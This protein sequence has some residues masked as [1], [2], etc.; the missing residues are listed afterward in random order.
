VKIGITGV[1]GFIGSNL[2]DALL[3][4]GHSVIGLDNLSM[5][6]L[7]NIEQHARCPNFEF[8]KVDVRDL[9]GMAAAFRHVDCVIHLAAF[10]IPRY[11]KAIETL[12][13][14]STGGKNV[15]EVC[16]D[17]SR[18]AVIAS[19]SDIYGKNPNLPFREDSD[20]LIGPTIIPR[21]SYAVSKLFD[22]H[23]SLA[24]YSGYGLPVTI[25]RFFG[26]YGPRQHLTWWGGPQS[27]F[28]SAVLNDKPM[29]IHGD[30]KQT[31]SFTYIADLIDG[32]VRATEHQSDTPQVFN[33]GNTEEV[34]ILDLARL[35]HELCGTGG[36]IN[37]K[38]VPY[39]SIG[40]NYEDV[41]RRIPDITKARTL[42]GFNPRVSLR[43]GLVPTIEWQRC[44]M[45]EVS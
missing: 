14:N 24:Y 27:V 26:S 40:G 34:T 42:L 43:D 10:K 22:E 38:M 31:R 9:D 5:G 8:C 20:S 18:R 45:A 29:E 39:A 32:I 16:R 28:I 21:W 19:T 3:G 30:G 11:G 41:P 25:L 37:L 44:R 12:E 23:L 4:R 35:V 7:R 2:S 17:G 36:P 1:A 33:L 13:I 6:S 15:L